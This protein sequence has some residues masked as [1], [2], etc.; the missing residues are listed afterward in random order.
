MLRNDYCC[1][2]GSVIYIL[3]T[4]R[5]EKKS[6]DHCA[7]QPVLHLTWGEDLYFSTLDITYCRPIVCARNVQDVAGLSYFVYTLTFLGRFSR[8]SVIFSSFK[9]AIKSARVHITSIRSHT[10][11]RT[12]HDRFRLNLL[13]SSAFDVGC[14]GLD[15]IRL[16]DG[17]NVGAK[18]VA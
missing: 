7:H 4:R 9:C 6:T 14:C 16:V 11:P 15:T 10:S 3:Y 2:D 12:Q 5:E 8:F 13:Y 18:Y 1:R 17:R